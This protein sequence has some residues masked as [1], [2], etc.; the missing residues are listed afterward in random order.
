MALE[1]FELNA[2]YK[3]VFYALYI[4]CT[5]FVCVTLSKI[6]KPSSRDVITNSR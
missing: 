5:L 1:V 2:N 6:S 3:Y 4:M